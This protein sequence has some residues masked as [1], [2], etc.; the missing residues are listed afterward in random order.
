MAGSPG[1][2]WSRLP[3]APAC[4]STQERGLPDTRPREGVAVQGPALVLVPPLCC[5]PCRGLVCPS[6]LRTG[7]PRPPGT[8]VPS[9]G[10]WPEQEGLCETP[11][12]LGLFTLRGTL[13]LAGLNRVPSPVPSSS[14]SPVSLAAPWIAGGACG[15][16]REEVAPRAVYRSDGVSC[17][18][19]AVCSV[20]LYQNRSRSGAAPGEACGAS[21]GS[22]AGQDQSRTA[23]GR[24]CSPSPR[25]DSRLVRGSADPQAG[26]GPR[27]CCCPQEVQRAENP[28]GFGGR[29]S[30]GLRSGLR[31]CLGARLLFMVLCTINRVTL[32][33]QMLC[34]LL[35][36]KLLVLA[37]FLWKAVFLRLVFPAQDRFPAA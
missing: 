18:L 5:S 22:V 30:G 20:A 6:V 26:S 36:A 28:P 21:A 34:L 12:T 23:R 4:A 13:L 7:R 1:Y 17:S 19:L 37:F 35:V 25:S 15:A 3:S 32:V 2:L 9:E 16:G 31:S 29:G 24:R 10:R 11:V 8:A 33:R 27:G 14:G